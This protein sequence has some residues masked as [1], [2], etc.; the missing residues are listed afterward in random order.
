MSR[1]E[2]QTLRVGHHS[3]GSMRHGL[4]MQFPCILTWG[5]PALPEVS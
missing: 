1:D 3:S 4:V 2:N 5:Q